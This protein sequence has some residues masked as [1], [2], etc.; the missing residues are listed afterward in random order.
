MFL[1]GRHKKRRVIRT[2]KS[3]H[4][5]KVNNRKYLTTNNW[6]RWI[7]QENWQMNTKLQGIIFLECFV[8]SPTLG[9]FNESWQWFYGTKG[10]KLGKN[11]SVP[12]GRPNGPVILGASISSLLTFASV[13]Q[14]DLEA[15]PAGLLGVEDHCQ[16]G[17]GG[18]KGRFHLLGVTPIH[19]SA[20][21][22]GHRR[23]RMSKNL[24]YV[25]SVVE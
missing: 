1:Q 3:N 8:W 12:L 21:A 5:Y 19:S 17:A 16:P 6:S 2:S 11:N 23:S 14:S 10:Q 20:F 24:T 22:A 15:V 13:Q 4:K 9:N 18:Q 7:K 25:H